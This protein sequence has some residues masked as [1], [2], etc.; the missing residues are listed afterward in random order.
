MDLLLLQAAVILLL[1][2]QPANLRVHPRLHRALHLLTG[3]ARPL[4]LQAAP[5]QAKAPAPRS[6]LVP[7]S[8]RA[9][10]TTLRIIAYPPPR[11]SPI[12]SPGDHSSA[13]T[14]N[15]IAFANRSPA[16]SPAQLT[17]SCNG[18]PANGASMSTSCAPR[19]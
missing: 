16:I 8:S 11:R 12:F 13:W 19:P 5:Y 3:T 6:S 14:R 4:C 9:P 15:K 17:K 18:S 2:N 10:T 1:E 7:R